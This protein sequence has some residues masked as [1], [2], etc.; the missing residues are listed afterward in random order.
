MNE[1]AFWIEKGDD[2]FEPTI[3]TQ[4]PWDKRFQHGGPPGALLVRQIEKCLPRPDTVLARISIDIFGPVPLTTLKAHARLVR[5]GR[6]VEKLEALLEH[7]GRPVM[8]ATGWRIRLPEKRPVSVEAPIRLPDY[9]QLPETIKESVPDPSTGWG[10]GYINAMEWRYA[11]G[12]F[13]HAGAALVWMRMRYPLFEGE[14]TSPYQH[15]IMS[16]DSAN[17]VS[18]LLDIREWQ[19][20]PPELTIHCLR[21]PAGEWICLEASTLIQTEGVGLTNANLYDERGLAGRSA[22]ALFLSHRS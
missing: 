6:S 8:R 5:P 17:G 18:G 15:L 16:A 9:I 4:G 13:T 2:L 22:Q 7:E 10:G 12:D 20:I 1:Q 14:E 21:P 19:F 3:H 11:Q